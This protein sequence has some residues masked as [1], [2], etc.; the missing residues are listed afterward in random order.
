MYILYTVF[1]DN[2]YKYK[3]IERIIASRGNLMCSNCSR[4]LQSKRFEGKRIVVTLRGMCMNAHVT[5]D[6]SLC[7]L[8]GRYDLDDVVF[9]CNEC[10]IEQHLEGFWIGCVERHSQYLFDEDLF[11]FFDYLQKFNPGLSVSGF[12][13]TLEEFSAEKNRVSNDDIY[14]I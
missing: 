9:Y 7:K 6:D 3:L 11:L 14:G 13:H 5:I 1:L 12:L 4:T 2:H 10:K 8:L